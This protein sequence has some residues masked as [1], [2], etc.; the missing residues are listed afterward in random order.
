MPTSAGKSADKD[1]IQRHAY[2]VLKKGTF[3]GW[4]ILN[5]DY[6]LCKS[7]YRWFRGDSRTDWVESYVDVIDG[8]KSHGLIRFEQRHFDE[9][10]KLHKKYKQQDPEFRF[11]GQGKPQ[12]KKK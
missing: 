1:V 8:M 5:H 7:I 10:E 12:H 2:Y 3:F 11:E 6:T 9:V 4:C